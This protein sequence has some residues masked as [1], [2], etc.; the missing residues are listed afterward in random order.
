MAILVDSGRA[1]VATAIMNQPIHLAWGEGQTSWDAQTPPEETS[2]KGLENELGRLIA[3]QVKYC[4]LNS[5]GTIIVAGG[6]FKEMTT[7]TNYLYMRF[8][9]NF[10]DEEFANIRELGIFVGTV[11]N[12]NLTQA[13][14]NAYM[15]KGNYTGGQLLV[16]ENLDK[17][18]R[19]PQVRQQFEFV[20][21]F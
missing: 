13:E 14:Q 15:K 1:A 4:E 18:S 20:I 10:K 7:P 5:A 6:T 16:L 12:A 17:L 21:Q 9:F 2:K 8:T 3:T 19:S 11:P